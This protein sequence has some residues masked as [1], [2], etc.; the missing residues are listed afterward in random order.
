MPNPLAP[1][2]DRV[3]ADTEHLWDELRG[4]RLFVTGGTGFVGCWLLETFLWANDALNLGASIV[5]LTRNPGA[6]QRKAPHLATHAAL[7]L[8]QGD[9]RTFTY[10]RGRFDCVIHA[11]TD[12]ASRPAED[13]AVGLFDAIVGGTRRALEFARACG[14]VRF[15]LTSSGAV[16]GRQPADLVQIPEDYEGASDSTDIRQVYGEGKR[17]AEML[18]A[19]AASQG[20]LEVKIAR[21]FAFVG[22]YLPLDAHFAVGNFI[23]DGLTGGPILVS[24]DGTPYR[25]YLYAADLATWLWTIL[26][27]GESMRPYNVGSAEQV[28]VAELADVVAHAFSPRPRIEIRGI[29]TPATQAQRSVP[30]VSRAQNELRLRPRVSLVDGIRKTI[31]W[32]VGARHAVGAVR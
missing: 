7:E 15:L 32:H 20:R 6:F 16:Y 29:P 26:V 4:Q 18:C 11:A 3:L 22:P 23:R 14:A 5:L 2:L 25:S 19:L 13:D 10:P 8:H 28:T 12:V 30:S 31:A 21:C 17:A 27:R 1:D 24:G 9:V